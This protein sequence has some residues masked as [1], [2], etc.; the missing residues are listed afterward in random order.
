[1]RLLAATAFLLLCYLSLAYAQVY[2]SGVAGSSR[3]DA[4]GGFLRVSPGPSSQ[5]TLAELTAELRLLAA[6][7]QD[8]TRVV[9]A[10]VVSLQK[11][12]EALK[13]TRAPTPPIKE[14]VD[15]PTPIRSQPGTTGPTG[16]E[17]LAG[18][19][20]PTR[21][22]GL[23][24]QPGAAGDPGVPG[25]VGPPGPPGPSGHDADP[26]ALDALRAE[27]DALRA[28]YRKELAAIKA[29]LA[30]PTRTRVEPIK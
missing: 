25:P 10:E 18:R 8:L 30:S 2:Q 12:I 26:R 6:Q 21:S 17:S 15:E 27:V 5:L 7:V 29:S 4:P 24:G 11:E 3:Q 28:E 23:A 14:Q 16:P 13:A 20:G 19:S 9:D 1:M 22:Q